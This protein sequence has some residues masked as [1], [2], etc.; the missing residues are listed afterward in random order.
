MKTSLIMESDAILPSGS[1]VSPQCGP[2]DGASGQSSWWGSAPSGLHDDAIIEAVL[3]GDVE[4]FAELVRRY[5][6]ATLKLAYS[7]IGNRDD[8]MELTQNAFVNA[9]RHLASFH[10]G[11][12]FSTWLYRITLNECKDF[13]KHAAARPRTVSTDAAPDTDGT[14]YFEIEDGHADPR[15]AT[16][17]RELARRLHQEITQLPGRQRTAFVLH[18][19]NGC[20]LDDTAHAMACR[21][22]TVKAQ[23]FR[24][25]D[26]LRRRLQRSGVKEEWL[27]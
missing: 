15:R 12:K 14:G 19:L 13:Y 2:E 16:A 24:A 21:I 20:S 10:R 26:R 11:A 5:Q 25:C 17:N 4:R 23:L 1:M 6:R 27:S 3:C 22:G 18:H 7:W 9:Y 8:A